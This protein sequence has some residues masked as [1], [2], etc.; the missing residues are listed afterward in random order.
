MRARVTLW[1]VAGAVGWVASHVTFPAPWGAFDMGVSGHGRLFWAAFAVLAGWNLAR[2][3][4][5]PGRRRATP[6]P[7]GPTVQ[8][9]PPSTTTQPTVRVEVPQ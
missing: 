1:A 9:V 2:H 4:R 8:V 6:P 3:Y 5:D 7:A